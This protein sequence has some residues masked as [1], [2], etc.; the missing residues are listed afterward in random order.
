MHCELLM[1]KRAASIKRKHRGL[2]I[3]L[4]NV[5]RVIEL[6]ELVPIKNLAF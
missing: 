6:I 4:C 2:E 1:H 5:F 3:A